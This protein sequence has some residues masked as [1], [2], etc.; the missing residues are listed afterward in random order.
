MSPEPPGLRRM[1]GHTQ[2]SWPGGSNTTTHCDTAV[3]SGINTCWHTS[4]YCHCVMSCG[5]IATGRYVTSRSCEL[6]WC[7]LPCGEAACMSVVWCTNSMQGEVHTD[8][9]ISFAS[10]STSAA[11]AAPGQ[12]I[13]RSV[14]YTVCL[15]ISCS[16]T[17]SP[18]WQDQQAVCVSK[19]ALCCTLS[20]AAHARHG[21]VAD[22]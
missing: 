12:P 18:S 9:S 5:H 17:A 10:T 2:E 8:S 6:G 22:A 4:C 15:R 13:C 21:M 16:A 11:A 14:C 20:L 19:P 3:T 7:E 1:A